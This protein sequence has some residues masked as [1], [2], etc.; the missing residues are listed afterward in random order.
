MD[1]ASAEM[2]AAYLGRSLP[3]PRPGRSVM[4]DMEEAGALL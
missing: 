3:A 2:G 1:L 4:T